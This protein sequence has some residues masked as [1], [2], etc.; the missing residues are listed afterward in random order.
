MFI[1]Y[2]CQ[3]DLYNFFR[4]TY[5]VLVWVA[6]ENVIIQVEKQSFV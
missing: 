4:R 2:L 6:R 1:I 5:Q 3:G